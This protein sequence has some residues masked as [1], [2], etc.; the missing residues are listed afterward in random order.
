MKEKN[1]NTNVQSDVLNWFTLTSGTS[2]LQ[3]MMFLPW[4]ES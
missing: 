4:K 2:L 3:N 1:E